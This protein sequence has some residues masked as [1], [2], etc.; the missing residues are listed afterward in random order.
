MDLL[1][2]SQYCGESRS[3]ISETESRVHHGGPIYNND[4]AVIYEKIYE[5]ARGNMWNQPSNLS[6]ATRIV[7]VL[8]NP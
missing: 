1:V 6:P 8:F 2:A 5:V 3:L 7:V 4:N